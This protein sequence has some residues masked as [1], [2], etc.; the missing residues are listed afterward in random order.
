MF[1]KEVIT[2][3]LLNSFVVATAPFGDPQPYNPYGSPP[4]PPVLPAP[5]WTQTKF[6]DAFRFPTEDLTRG[7]CMEDQKSKLQD[8]FNEV[9]HL[10]RL[11]YD[12][13]SEEIRGVT[14]NTDVG[15]LMYYVFGVHP[16]YYISNPEGGGSYD[17]G[18]D[19]VTARTPTEFW[20]LQHESVL[21]EG[22]M[23]LIAKHGKGDLSWNG[24]Q[25]IRI[26]R[27]YCD[28]SWLVPEKY[29]RDDKGAQTA[30]KFPDGQRFYDAES[31]YFS[32]IPW[33]GKFELELGMCGPVGPDPEHTDAIT[34]LLRNTITFCPDVWKPDHPVQMPIAIANPIQDTLSQ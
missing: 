13:V 2:I 20:K 31:N 24:L 23:V 9:M 16:S 10:A 18:E 32:T 17:G 19:P 15:D 25:K 27:L 33:G 29:E 34:D 22:L 28:S 6:F 11:V 5:D 3:L 1:S 26:T 14:T 4:S 12:Y 30:I 7:C 21:H 8:V